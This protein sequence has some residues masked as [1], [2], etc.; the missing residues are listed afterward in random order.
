M[1]CRQSE[2][3]AD[4]ILLT[5]ARYIFVFLLLLLWPAVSSAG[6]IVDER[7]NEVAEIS[8]IVETFVPPNSSGGIAVLVT[9]NGQ[10]IHCKGYGLVSGSQVTAQT[11]LSLA[12]VTKQ[13]AAMC[14]AMMIEAGKL[15]PK[16][17]VS[18]YLPD[19]NIP[20]KG[21]ELLVQDLLWH[22]S[23]LANF[24]SKKEQASIAEFRRQRN[25]DFLTNRTHAEWLATL[26]PRRPPGQQFEYTNSGY[27]LLA[28]II[29]V[30]TGESFHDFQK[31]RIFD[32]LEL[33]STT[34]STRF[35]GSGNMRTT[36]LDFAKWDRALWEQDPRLLS[37]VG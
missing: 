3:K 27:V 23:G 35:N 17:K 15:D 5:P 36:L 34:D 11:P 12:S 24:I 19:L 6:P 10:V 18:H 8:R 31:R 20:V 26:E 9:R 2:L 4:M 32:V 14:A 7:A 16:E 1:D 22:T 21:R 25:L 28:R 13:F 29:E 37:T 33:T 30:I